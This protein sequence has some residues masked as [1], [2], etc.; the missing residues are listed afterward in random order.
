MDIAKNENPLK[1][2]QL[3]QELYRVQKINYSK[4]KVLLREYQPSAY[5]RPWGNDPEHIAFTMKLRKALEQD[6]AA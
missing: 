5:C 1:F 3:T 2:G 6:A 4:L